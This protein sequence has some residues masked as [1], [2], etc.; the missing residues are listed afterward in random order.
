ML[1]GYGVCGIQIRG[2]ISELRQPINVSHPANLSCVFYFGLEQRHESNAATPWLTRD[3]N[4][5]KD[6]RRLA[7]RITTPQQWHS[8]QR[9]LGGFDSGSCRSPRARGCSSSPKYARSGG[10]WCAGSPLLICLRRA[11]HH[12]SHGNVTP[13]E[14]RT[15][16]PPTFLPHTGHCRAAT[17]YITELA[18]AWQL[19]VSF[20][21]SSSHP[22]DRESE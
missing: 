17:S 21:P 18:L 19:H 9:T 8:I 5:R 3:A 15:P 20:G 11:S 14:R 6:E 22:T 1:E 7:Q 10:P 4:D 13:S 12:G 2:S 16:L